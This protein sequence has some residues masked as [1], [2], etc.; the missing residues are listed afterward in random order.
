[1][2]TALHLSLGGLV[3]LLTVAGLNESLNYNK[4]YLHFRLLKPHTK[5]AETTC[6]AGTDALL[7]AGNACLV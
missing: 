2:A 7:D 4:S 3:Q 1:M 6:C 5:V